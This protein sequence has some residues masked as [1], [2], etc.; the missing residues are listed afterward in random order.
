[1]GEG[2]SLTEHD[3][4]ALIDAYTDQTTD[5]AEFVV[6]KKLLPDEEDRVWRHQC[7]GF[8]GIPGNLITCTLAHGLALASLYDSETELQVPGDDVGAHS[9]TSTT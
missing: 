5:F 3:L 1:V 8:L 6:S 9:R 7:A 2:I 4:G